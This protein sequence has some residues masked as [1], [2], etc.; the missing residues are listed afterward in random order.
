MLEPKTPY[1]VKVGGFIHVPNWYL[2]ERAIP[3]DAEKRKEARVQASEFTE[4]FDLKAYAG[5][6]L[7]KRLNRAGGIA[8]FPNITARFL[9]E[10][11]ASSR[12]VDIELATAPDEVHVVK[13]WHEKF[14]GDQTSF[15]VS[16]N[17]AADASQLEL[18][19]EMTER[20]L[21]WAQEATG[22]ERH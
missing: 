4:W 1:Y 8:E 13:R 7:H 5:K 11:K 6:G 21:R 16:P 9:S 2:P 17:L 19:S 22:G 12:E 15:L 10:P 18:A 14:E 20:R 3:T